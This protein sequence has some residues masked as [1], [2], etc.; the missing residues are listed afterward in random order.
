MTTAHRGLI[1]I[2]ALFWALQGCFNPAPP[3]GV[4][5]A[6]DGWC[7]SG[8]RC[9][10]FTWMCVASETPDAGPWTD[11]GFPWPPYDAFPGQDG[12]QLT[13]IDEALMSY[14][15]VNILIPEVLVTYVKPATTFESAGFFVQSE[16]SGP[17]LFLGVDPDLDGARLAVGDRVSFRLLEM[18]DLDGLPM[19]TYIDSVVIHGRGESVSPLI[20]DVTNDANFSFN[21][22]QYAAELISATFLISGDYTSDGLESGSFQIATDAYFNEFVRLRV[23][24]T[25]QALAGLEYGCTLTV[26]ATPVWQVYYESFLLAY[27]L[28]DF[29]NVDCPAPQVEVAWAETSTL[30]RIDFTRAID[31]ATLAADGSQFAINGGL[32]AT[33]ATVSGRL[34][35]I[36][37]TQ[38]V[39]GQLYAMTIDPSLR[40]V[41]GKGM[42]AGSVVN[43]LGGR[44]R[45]DLRINEVKANITPGCDLVELR[46]V[47]PGNLFGFD[48]RVQ[49]STVLTFNEELEVERNDIIVVHF[50]SNDGVCRG[51]Q[52]S[53][54]TQAPNEQ[55]SSQHP[56]NFDTAYDWYVPNQGPAAGPSVI[57]VRDDEDRILDA[58][59][60]TDS[61]MQNTSE[62][63][64]NAAA[65]VVSASQWQSPNGGVPPGGFVDATFHEAAA[66]GADLDPANVTSG[67]D[68]LDGLR[69]VQRS[70]NADTDRRGDWTA[71]EHTFGAPNAGQSPL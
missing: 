49:N 4:L 53:N 67:F 8:Q 31:P 46:V 2:A 30:L 56:T 54:E 43:F 68:A 59:L 5:C 41:L 66:S 1:G 18:S 65:L 20:Q 28:D 15:P 45:A 13:G 6:P 32:T 62:Q 9:D 48:L 38:Q 57:V 50:D 58:V 64:E 27:G 24:E 23:P 25:L 42:P 35:T 26:P 61:L 37:T 29:Q 14:G 47:Q 44:T 71:V 12:G 55:P 40:D 69:S 70:S 19:G 36:T 51:F 17:A 21:T 3:S 11:S 7:P 39:D 33:S 63:T 60:L 22:F 34:V 52:T 10:P 16:Q